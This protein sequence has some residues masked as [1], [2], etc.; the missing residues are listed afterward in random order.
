MLSLF[1]GNQIF[2]GFA[3]L[4]YIILLRFSTFALPSDWQPTGAGVFSQAVYHWVG[5]HTLAA[6]IVSVALI[7]LQAV[8]LNTMS[9]QYRMTDETNFFVG[10]FYVLLACYI[11]D[12]L[13]LSP[14]LMANTFMVIA[15]FSL[16]ETYRKHACADHIFNTGLWVGVASLFY[17]STIV[18]ILLT[19]LGLGILR[20][21]KWRERV[22]LLCGLVVPLFLTFTYYLW[23][24]KSD[25]FWNEQ[26]E[27][28][29]S[30]LN[31]VGELQAL[32]YLK[33]GL[34]GALLLIAL[35]NANAYGMKRSIQVQKY[36]QVLYVW[37]VI[38][39][40]PLLFQSNI[41]LEYLL[42]L[43]IPLGLFLSFTFSKMRPP[44][45]DALHILLFTGA[46]LFQYVHLVG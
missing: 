30:F 8:A 10:V 16:F 23:N 19:F 27:K 9:V 28:N 13:H 45:A 15:L 32:D 34:F 25:F 42:M 6:N 3:L 46:L 33:L 40:A 5:I 14:I 18:F 2:A 43:V 36:Q 41:G 21:F 31:F 20:P 22:I 1:R 11:P 7:F 37:F 44:V 24:N 39:A 4:L 29:I 35:F 17:G 26:I 38:A 12:F